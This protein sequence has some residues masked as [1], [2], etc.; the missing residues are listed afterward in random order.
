LAGAS[1]QNGD[2]LKNARFTKDT[3][4]ETGMSGVVSGLVLHSVVIAAAAAW[5]IAIVV[6]PDI[7][8][9]RPM[10]RPMPISPHRRRSSRR[11][12]RAGRERLGPGLGSTCCSDGG[13]EREKHEITG[14]KLQH[15]EILLASPC[16]RILAR[17]AA[18]R[19]DD[20]VA[21]IPSAVAN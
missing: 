8:V 16:K 18:I 6:V 12:Y 1:R 9:H 2:T 19:H 10:M 13:S 3:A 20:R 4:D 14:E 5:Q 11:V 15:A 21:D 7:I 17:I